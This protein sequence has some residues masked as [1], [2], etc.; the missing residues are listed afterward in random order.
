MK[1]NE[2]EALVFQRASEYLKKYDSSY[3]QIKSY[4]FFINHRLSKI[5]EEEPIIEIQIGDNK[6]YNVHFGQIFVDKPYI[7]DENRQI[8]Y[9]TPNEARLRDLTYSSLISVNI[10]TFIT[11]KNSNNEI[12]NESNVQEFYKINLARIPMM[13]GTSKCNLYG[14]TK[15]QKIDLGECEFDNGGYF[16]IKGKE[17][18][19]VSQERINYNIVHIFDTKS[20]SKFLMIA[21]VRSMSEETGHSVLLQM[22]LT[23]HIENKVFLQIPYVS[24]DIPLGYIFKAFDFSKEELVDILDFNLKNEYENF[25]IISK[26][27]QNIIK[28]FTIISTQEKA[29][30]YIAQFSIHSLSKERKFYYINQILNNEL[31]PHLGII[32]SKSQK[33]FFLGHMLSKLLFTFVK[34]RSI[35]DRDHINN[36]RLE[37][38]GHL[39]SELFRTLFKRFVRSMQPQLAKRHDILVV[40]GRNNIISQGIKHCF[41]TG[42]WGIP[43]SNYIRTGVSQILSRLTYNSFQ[44]HL[45]RI[46]IP[47]GK[48]GKNTKIRQLHTSQ[49]GYICPFETPEGHCL[50]PDTE[51]LL[52]DNISTVP[53]AELKHLKTQITT[54]NLETFKKEKSYIHNFFETMPEE[55]YKITLNSERTIKASGLHPFLVCEKNQFYWKKANEIKEGDLLAT[56][57]VPKTIDHIPSNI[58]MRI[59]GL[60]RSTYNNDK[61]YIIIPP[62]LHFKKV[63][64]DIRKIFNPNIQY[65]F[66]NRIIY[67][68]IDNE[69]FKSIIPVNMKKG[70]IRDFLMGFFCGLSFDKNIM[71][72]QQYKDVSHIHLNIDF[73]EKITC[74]N[75]FIKNIRTEF[76]IRF[77]LITYSEKNEIFIIL[78]NSPQNIKNFI[79][80]FGFYYNIN[81]QTDLYIYSEYL[82]SCNMS[83]IHFMKD[84]RILKNDIVFIP[85]KTIEK[86]KV[87]LTMDFTTRSNNH[88]FIANGF[89]THNSSGIV[90][91]MTL[92]T[93]LTTKLNSVFIRMILE[94]IDKIV[95]DFNNVKKLIGKNFLKIFLDGNWIG[96]TDD[97]STYDDL[98][99]YKMIGRFPNYL[100]ISININ[101]KEILLFSDEGRMIRPLFSVKN[102]P[103]MDDL[104]TKSF[105]QL[106]KEKKIVLLDSYEI[107][108]NVIAMTPQEFKFKNC[109][110]LCEIHPSFINGLC[111]GLIPYCEHTQAPRITYHASMG[112]QAIGLYST[113]NDIRADTIVHILNYPEKPLV[114]THIGEIS[115]C[116]QLVFGKN[117]IV[118]VAMYS[119][120]N[121][122]DSVILNKSAI[123]RGLFRS[124]AY[125]TIS[126]EERKKSTTYTEDIILPP[127]ELRIK[128][129][130]YSKLDAQGIVKCGIYVGASDVIVGRV[131][132][133]T[134]KAYGEEKSDV[135]VAIKSGEEGY[136]DR[137]FISNSPE[138]Y[139][140]V[141]VKIRSLKIPE[142]GDKVA[143]RAAQKGTI[144]MIFHQ[145]D[146]PFVCDTGMIPDIIINPLCLP[147]RMTINQIIECIAAKSCAFEG[148]FCYG[149]PFTEHSI[150]IVDHL[151]HALVKNGFNDNGKEIMCN[152]FTGEKFNASIFIGPTYYHR[153]KHLV[154]AK[155]H[156]RNHG[157]LQALTRQPVEGRSR[158]GG[159]RFGEM[160]RDAIRS[161]TPISLHCGLSIK[162]DDMYE[163]GWKLL[164]WDKER[165]GIIASTQTEFLDKGYREC[166]E[167]MLEDGRKIYPSIKHPFLTSSNQW[168]I[169]QNINP[170][171][172]LKVN[173]EN[174]LM[175]IDQ[176]IKECDRWS[177]S[178]GELKFYTD[179]KQNYLKTLAFI[180][181]LGWLLSDHHNIQ[182]GYIYVNHI[183]DVESLLED[184][185]LVFSIEKTFNYVDGKYYIIYIDSSMIKNLLSTDKTTN[186]IQIPKIPQFLL[187]GKCP[188]YIIREFLGAILG[189]DANT[190]Q[191]MNHNS[192]IHL[193]DSV[194][195]SKSVHY[196]FMNNLVE[197]CKNL[198]LL[199]NKCGINQ[200]KIQQPINDKKKK[201]SLS[202]HIEISD[203]LKFHSLIGFR[204]CL[205]KSLRLEAIV[206]YMRL[207]ETMKRQHN[208]IIHKVDELTN[209]SE[210]KKL[211][212][213]KKI[214]TKH[215]IIKAIQ[216]L[217]RKEGLVHKNVIPSTNNIRKYVM[218][219]KVSIYPAFP[220]VEDYLK[221][222]D[223]FDW[224]IP[225]RNIQNFLP[226]MNLKVISVKS[227]GTHKVFDIQ[228]DKTE[229]FL[230]NGVVAHNCMISHGVSRFLTERLF[231]M[232]DIFSVPLCSDCGTMPHTNEICN[233][234]D[235]LNIT[236]ILIPY[237]CKLLFQELMAMGIKINMFTD[238]DTKLIKRL[239]DCNLKKLI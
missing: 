133:K 150:D 217:D 190:C 11:Q 52:S 159:L 148:K 123:D 64:K 31:F 4:D 57:Y 97:I 107:E 228:V 227:I 103:T 178:I 70:Y 203:L 53:I 168:I 193:L 192:K 135:S 169:A 20:A 15:Q 10:R 189:A 92:L 30:S 2:F 58:S 18:V 65:D 26:I 12:I 157:S 69:Y 218:K 200:I 34:K 106:I 22:K 153:L 8:R 111:V 79:E 223:A 219:D 89:L 125:R 37:A 197:Y 201:Y 25:P 102:F 83:I 23:N 100:S 16:I 229:S 80:T 1:E 46:L 204:H 172:I 38:S 196:S 63:L 149:T 211:D 142:I 127:K 161:N 24:Q 50:T 82:N 174:P 194:N 198:E 205:Q 177:L 71:D 74:W 105:E 84:I 140:I 81:I 126:V 186:G 88:N 98:I 238:D 179:T 90:K 137:V 143:S 147:S 216:E 73:D 226:T 112:K 77:D 93:H 158:D 124:F 235:S 72:N 95:F 78:Q 42:N 156:A 184:I 122:E 182:D 171:T 43:K 32:S 108:N 27:A 212:P 234:C 176:E 187:E 224:F 145:E 144:G 28:D 120:F 164:S 175:D 160:E 44:S 54:I 208:W 139:K 222:I 170:N 6:Y 55:L 225:N 14:K 62:Q 163:K 35:D 117:L 45:R 67:Y 75:H 60:I 154:S 220:T 166:L 214:R 128:S 13:I 110:T 237:A 49:I 76:D 167:I 91:N 138:G 33:G 162:I 114:K 209:Y 101:E 215:A 131:Q 165:N 40:M 61:K 183:L 188:K 180:R 85:V 29:I 21:E 39:I 3:L 109:Y 36:K 136:I 5:I 41:S 68:Q 17:R 202:L 7:I 130:N 191:L 181:I 232:S 115:D 231:D 113:T 213:N 155:I 87:Q 99:K 151:C 239:K 199:F 121:Q 195:L 210:M 207:R 94:E 119:G 146:M 47:I 173:I 152:G 206:S 56:K 134:I 96:C 66:E 236:R 9:I 118:A 141:K 233:V 221:Q 59:I 116:N 104:K 48:E 132:T 86:I 19:L 51:I 185:K 129:Y 230:A